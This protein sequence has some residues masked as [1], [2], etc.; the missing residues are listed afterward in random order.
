MNCYICNKE[1]PQAFKH[2]HHILPQAV[3]GKEGATVDLCSGCHNNLH[4]II[5]IIMNKDSIQ[6]KDIA[7]QYYMD[8]NVVERIL[9]LAQIA[10]KQILQYDKNPTDDSPVEIHFTYHEKQRIQ[11]A[12]QDQNLSMQKFVHDLIINYLKSKGL[13]RR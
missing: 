2:T 8:S 5:E 1:L 13:Y 10:V 12:A 3:G 4:R 11:I 7:N 6:A 9:D